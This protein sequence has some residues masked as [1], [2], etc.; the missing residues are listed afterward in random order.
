MNRRLYEF[1]EYDRNSLDNTLCKKCARDMET[2]IPECING[3]YCM[4]SPR[5]INSGILTLAFVDSQPLDTV[6]QTD[7]AFCRGTLFPN[8]DKPFYGGMRNE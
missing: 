7:M 6:Y 2:A 5:N 8:I 3:D 1:A 4:P